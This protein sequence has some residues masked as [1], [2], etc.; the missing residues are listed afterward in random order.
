M[1]GSR[2]APSGRCDLVVPTVARPSLSVLLASLAPQLDDASTRVVVVDDRRHPSPALPDPPEAL[3]G[4]VR[5]LASGGRGPAAAR[6]LGWRSSSAEWVVFLDDD[7]V[8]PPGWFAAL[9]E[10]LAALPATVA[11]SQGRI[12]VPLP[13]DRAPTDWERNV[14]SLER[15]NWVTADMAYRRRALERVGGFDE[16]FP[17]AYRED[18]DLA[19]RIRRAGYGLVRGRR[20]VWHPVREA[21]FGVSL[22]VQAGNAEDPFMRALHGA[23]WREDVGVARGRRRQHLVTVATAFGALAAIAS[24]R[25]RLAALAAAGWAGFTAELAWHRFAPGPRTPDELGRMLVT[26]LLLPFAAVWHWSW[27]ALAV[28]FRLRQPAPGEQHASS[29]PGP[30]RHPSPAVEALPPVPDPTTP[31]GPLP[32]AVLFD[33]DGT[34]VHDVPYNGDP[35]A[36]RLVDG[37]REALE[38]LRSLRV[39]T[40]VITNQSGI[41][42]GLLTREQVDRVNARLETLLGP[43]GPW[44]I[45]PHAPEDGCNCRKPAPELIR[46]ACRRLGVDPADCVVIGDIESDVEAARAAG[47]RAVLVPTA[48]TRPEEVERAPLVARHLVEAVQLALRLTSTAKG[49]AA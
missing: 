41:G 25:R 16:R 31:A 4:R 1:S 37:A 11:G 17:R 49:G 5:I 20:R 36:V 18:A 21:G 22:R 24:G 38:L 9:S 43:L 30:H 15:A 39:P 42:R 34:L 33:R 45:C 23:A 29:G 48:V 13:Q 28:P 40:G 10:D 35:D 19:L 26:S 44:E 47:A 8:V 12:E 6:N 32:A 7:V 14:A 3:A 2:A 27:G 46:R